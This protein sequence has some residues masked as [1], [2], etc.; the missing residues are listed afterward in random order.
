MSEKTKICF[1]PNCQSPAIRDGNEII[2]EECDAT[3]K[4]EKVDGAKVKSTGRLQQIEERIEKLEKSILEDED[5]P[6]PENQKPNDEGNKDNNE[7][8]P[9]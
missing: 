1:C 7:F 4:V 2:C 5:Q 3:Y 9:R 6:E 8:L